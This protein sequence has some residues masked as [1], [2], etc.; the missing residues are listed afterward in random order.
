MITVGGNGGALGAC[1][2]YD[3]I[4]GAYD[5]VSVPDGTWYDGSNCPAGEELARGGILRWHSG[6]ADR[7]NGAVLEDNGCGEK[8]LCGQPWDGRELGGGWEICFA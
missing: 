1:S 5:W 3:M 6:R 2:V 4:G 7:T 8:G